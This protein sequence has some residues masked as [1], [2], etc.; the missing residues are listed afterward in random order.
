MC[1]I[2]YPKQKRMARWRAEVRVQ[3][4]SEESAKVAL[5]SLDVDEELHPEVVRRDM[6]VADSELVVRFASEDPK[7]LRNSVNGIFDMIA[8]VDQVFQT[9]FK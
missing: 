4:G 1:C 9:E 5:A 3:F 7:N 6:I 8:L 2:S